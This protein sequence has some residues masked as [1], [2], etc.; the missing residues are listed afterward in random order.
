MCTMCGENAPNP[1]FEW[2]MACYLEYVRAGGGSGGDGG[3]GRSGRGRGRGRGRGGRGRGGRGGGGGGYAGNGYAGHSAPPEDA[4]YEELLEWEESRG[5]AGPSKGASSSQ[6]SALPRRPFLGA[7]DAL[8]GDDAMCSVC[9]MEYEEGD[10]LAVLPACAH[11]FHAAC[12]G[13]WLAEKATCPVCMRDV[14]QDLVR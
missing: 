2:C 10:E 12:I 4:T 14:R 7:R 11:A 8:K 13:R 6:V 9:R 5:S 3:G 1:G